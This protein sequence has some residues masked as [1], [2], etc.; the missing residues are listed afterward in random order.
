MKHILVDKCGNCPHYRRLLVRSCNP[1]D[2]KLCM[3]SVCTE[4]G[5]YGEVIEDYMTIPEWCPLPN[6]PEEKVR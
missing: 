3:V 5:D 2:N 1:D 4:A 6:A